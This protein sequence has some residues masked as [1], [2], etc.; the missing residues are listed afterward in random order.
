[1]IRLNNSQLRQLAEFTSNLGLLFFATI[2]TQVFAD[3]D[4]IDLLNVVLGL[5]ASITALFLSLTILILNKRE[6]AKV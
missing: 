5:L 6:K 4:K 1:M 3:V 2:V